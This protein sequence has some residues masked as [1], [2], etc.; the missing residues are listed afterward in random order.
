VGSLPARAETD[1]SLEEVFLA[2][3]QAQDAG[4]PPDV[5]ALLAAHPEQAQA[6]LG[7]LD[8]EQA[9][10]GE[11]RP[12]RDA[13]LP[14]R[15]D[16]VPLGPFGEHDL[17][18]KIDQG[19]MGVVYRARHRLANREVAVKVIRKG[20][21]ASPEERQRFLFEARSAA[22]LEH[23][24]IVRIY[25][26]GTID[27]RPYFSMELARG[28][29]LAG[30][31]ERLRRAPRQAAELLRLVALAVEFAH[32][33][34][35]LHRDL[36]PANVL[37]SDDG[38]PRVADFGLAKDLT[39]PEAAEPARTALPSDKADTFRGDTT[40]HSGPVLPL[41]GP[42]ALLGTPWYMAP[43]QAR[44][45]KGVTVAVD[46]HGLGTIL[47][48]VLTGRPPFQGS[49]PAETLRQVCD[50]EP[51][52]PR[53]LDRKI[54]P[55]LE[56]ICLKCLRKAPAERYASAAGVADEMERFLQGRPVAARPV[57]G[58]M[59]LAMWGR[60]QP[61][62]AVLIAAVV[63]LIGLLAVAV[64]WQVARFLERQAEARWQAYTQGMALAGLQFRVGQAGATERGFPIDPLG[65][66]DRALEVC[67][68]EH[69]AWD[70]HYLRRLCHHEAIHLTGH[71]L[72]VI[73]VQ[74]SPDGS[75][76][77]TG[78]NDGTAR[79]W[80]P[81]SGQEL[82][83]LSP[84]PDPLR[85]ALRACFA[86]GGRKILT[87]G[88][89]T[90]DVQVHDAATLAL[91][92]VLPGAGQHAVCAA[93]G[94]WMVAVGREHRLRVYDQRSWTLYREE[95]LTAQVLCLAVSPDGRYLATG[96]Y[97]QPLVLREL[98]SCRPVALESW[99][100]TGNP[101]DA[102]VW[103]A[104]FSPDS[105]RLVASLPHPL[106]WELSSGKVVKA[107]V[108]TGLQNCT[109]LDFSRDGRFLA[110][111]C[112]DGQVR[113]W[114]LQR[115][116]NLRAPLK[117]HDSVYAAAFSP[118]GEA[119]AVTRGRQVIVEALHSRKIATH[120]EL[121]GHQAVNLESMT[122][123]HD[124]RWLASRAGT[125]ETVVWEMPSGDLR[126]RFTAADLAG[127]GGLAFYPH[128]ERSWLIAGGRDRLLAWNAQDGSSPPLRLSAKGARCLAVTVPP[129]RPALLA[130]LSGDRLVTLRDLESDREM[131]FSGGRAMIQTLAFHPDGKRLATGGSDGTL[132][133]HGIDREASVLFRGPGGAVLGLAFSPDGKLL[134]SCGGGPAVW[135]W[136]VERAQVLRRLSG[137]TATIKGVAFTP[138]GRRLA[139][140]SNDETIKVW[141]VRT[142]AELL[143]LLAPGPVTAIAFSPDGN[144]LASCG[145][146]GVVRIWDGRPL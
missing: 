20:A 6:L 105:K 21:L 63:I 89:A 78:G 131:S 134:A 14:T 48:E 128:A 42:G 38:T 102:R 64:A 110:A 82:G 101:P 106:Q 68:P 58:W 140:C 33:H 120:R 133:L 123:S 90:Q 54:H 43:E 87:A 71:G 138:D 132:R 65:R 46:V 129:G 75:R 53:R 50:A 144:L 44:G 142:G 100:R 136:D 18:E 22:V 23:P 34:G 24:N 97:D 25:E 2:Y 66:A 126:Q 15:G 96:T 74:Y 104:A 124:G 30:R 8:D 113:V 114:D 86:A 57:P 95:A 59:R 127:G 125:G 121:K 145:P 41:T 40:P 67:P 107:F 83:R 135:L 29:T 10:A 108:G 117:H 32:R 103:A 35:I 98:P 37:L 52:P 3:L 79:L 45:E 26:V 77:L 76:V 49:T 11:A 130:T 141:D 93:A 13:W 47:Y 72:D 19:G 61:L 60:R 122:F 85:Q 9:V 1:E 91:V 69:R 39:A 12:F 116:R 51:V 16:E 84:R 5:A 111:P 143:T 99:T 56:A 81:R 55:D 70:W 80:D 88:E 31:G 139:S 115:N 7:V 112:Q 36:K 94:R 146:D 4:R 62:L 137:H 28:G 118:D 119:L 109:M 92:R 73:S 17:V 27:D